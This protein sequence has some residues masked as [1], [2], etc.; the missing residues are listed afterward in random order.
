MRTIIAMLLA[1]VT[2]ATVAPLPAS[3]AADR[4]AR[5]EAAEWVKTG[6]KN[7]KT[8]LAALRQVKDEKS[9]DK[10]G[11]KLQK[12]FATKAGKQT[13]MGEVAPAQKPTGEEMEEAESKREKQYEKLDTAILAERERIEALNLSSSELK[14]GMELMDAALQ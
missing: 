13:A 8:A 6:L 10:V 4:A 2:L 1:C 11:K 12:D 14:K 7:R 9:A 3:A 5:K